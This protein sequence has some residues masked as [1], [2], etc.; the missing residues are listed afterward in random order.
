MRSF[1]SRRHALVRIELLLDHSLRSGL[2]AG[3]LV[4]GLELHLMMRRLR[5]AMHTVSHNF[6]EEGFLRDLC[7][8]SLRP[9]RLRSCSGRPQNQTFNR[10]ECK[11]DRGGWALL[12]NTVWATSNLSAA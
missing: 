9:L 7:G 11:G 1:S 2:L 4:L 10:K 6:G 3:R 5:L 8:I 12:V